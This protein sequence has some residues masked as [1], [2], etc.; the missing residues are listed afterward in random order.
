MDKT[1][2]TVFG[3]L[4]GVIHCCL[5]SSFCH[6]KICQ[7]ANE[8]VI[9]LALRTVNNLISDRTNLAAWQAKNV[10]TIKQNA[11]KSTHSIAYSIARII[12]LRSISYHSAS[13]PKIGS[14]GWLVP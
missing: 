10:A 13:L 2:V 12:R 14:A 4:R 5:H 7:P 1:F 3:L 8:L 6:L 11:I 9:C